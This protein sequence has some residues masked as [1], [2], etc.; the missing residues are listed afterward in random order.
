ML[1]CKNILQ[2]LYYKYYV[3][4]IYYNYFDNNYI[5]FILNVYFNPKYFILFKYIITI[6]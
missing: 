1:L 4:T 5:L 2:M 3:I 6:Y